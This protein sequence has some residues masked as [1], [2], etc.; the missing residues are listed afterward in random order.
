MLTPEGDYICVPPDIE[1]Q[2]PA[3]IDAVVNDP[4]SNAETPIVENQGVPQEGDLTPAQSKASG[5]DVDCIQFL[6][7]AEA[8]A[9]YNADP[10]DP[11][12]LDADGDGIAC[13][14]TASPAGVIEFEDGTVIGNGNDT[15]SAQ[16]ADPANTATGAQYADDDEVTN[17]P[18]TGGLPLGGLTAVGGFALVAG[19]LLLRHRLS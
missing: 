5:N 1:D 9:A 13:E 11:N 8:Q 17:L 7:Q 3:E 6:T 14:T 15:P 19:G 18:D 16:P 2:T 12:G 10:S 4:R